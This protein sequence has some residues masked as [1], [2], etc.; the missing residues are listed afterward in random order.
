M[1]FQS[2]REAKVSCG[3]TETG[4]RIPLRISQHSVFRICGP[5]L[6]GIKILVYPHFFQILKGFWIIK[7]FWFFFFFFLFANWN[8]RGRKDL[9]YLSRSKSR[10]EF[11]IS[12]VAMHILLCIPVKFHCL[13]RHDYTLA[14]VC[15]PH[16]IYERRLY[17]ILLRSFVD[18]CIPW[19]QG[20]RKDGALIKPWAA[21][22]CVGVHVPWSDWASY[23]Q[24]ESWLGSTITITK[25]KQTGFA[26]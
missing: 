20:D 6:F 13:K 17:I 16:R 15:L 19:S 8:M 4:H 12:P 1:F 22:G 21:F 2:Y 5:N 23:R 9:A 25:V 26:F 24:H 18:I 10:G 11:L 7:S 3:P 14:P